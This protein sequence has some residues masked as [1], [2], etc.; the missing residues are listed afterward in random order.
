LQ[1]DISF[2]TRL[3]PKLAVEQ[4]F[5]AQNAHAED[6]RHLDRLGQSPAGAEVIT[7]IGSGKDRAN[8]VAIQANG[9]I[10]VAGYAPDSSGKGAFTV[11]R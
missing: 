11:V 8:D 6:R 2:G 10:I 1:R 7:Q 4:G 5:D 9:K 3:V